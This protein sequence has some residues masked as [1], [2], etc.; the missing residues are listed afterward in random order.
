VTAYAF[1][2]VRFV[3]I[4]TIPPEMVLE[5]EANWMEKGWVFK[6]EPSGGGSVPN[7]AEFNDAFKRYGE[8]VKYGEELKKLDK[9]LKLKGGIKDLMDLVHFKMAIKSLISDYPV[10]NRIWSKAH[11]DLANEAIQ[12]L[13]TEKEGSYV[14]ASADRKEYYGK[15]ALK[16]FFSLLKSSISLP[17]YADGG[18][19]IP[20][21][22]PSDNV[23]TPGNT[24]RQRIGNSGRPALS[25]EEKKKACD[26]LNEEIKNEETI[27]AAYSDKGLLDAAKAKGYDG[28]EYNNCV[29]NAAEKASNEG[30]YK[31]F[32]DMS[33]G[34]QADVLKQP[35]A[36][37]II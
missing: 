20:W 25:D 18:D 1:K 17:V 35:G 24:S 8:S 13:I 33:P 31:N 23:G 11:A 14:W 30:G 19:K 15:S 26:K 7:S 12:Y 36:R 4:F 10:K 27:L 2:K 34:E 3:K 28:Y 32:N 6:G 22:N 9:V 16:T 37:R 21:F 5:L 29:K